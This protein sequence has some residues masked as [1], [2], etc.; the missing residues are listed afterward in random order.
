M[1]DDKVKIYKNPARKLEDSSAVRQ[2]YVPQYQ[3]LGVTPEESIEKSLPSN[4]LI[5]RGGSSDNDNPRTRKLS[6]RQPYVE[7][8][9]ST[10]ESSVTGSIPNVGNNMEQGWS[11]ID[12]EMVDDITGQV[13]GKLDDSRP[14]IDNNDFVEIPGLPLREEVP[15]DEPK[16]FMTAQELSEV[17]DDVK[18]FS[19]IQDDSYILFVSGTIIAVDT[20]EKIQS[21]ASSL[22]FGEHPLCDGQAIPIEDIVV[23]KK[24]KLKVGLFLE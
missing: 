4:V 9:V 14:M 11:Y 6:I 21:I 17:I 1:S 7:T 3:L 18:V 8:V 5:A 20:M 23:L 13:V 22:I 10:N 2:V 16:Q 19:K 12:N 15:Q 24:I